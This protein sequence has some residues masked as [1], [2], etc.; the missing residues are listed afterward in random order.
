MPLLET[1]SVEALEMRQRISDLIGFG[2]Y[3][4]AEGEIKRFR[5]MV[6]TEYPRVRQELLFWKAL[7]EEHTGTD[8]RTCLKMMFQ[9][10]HCTVPY[11][12]GKDMGYWVFQREEIII[13]S[14]IAILYR[15]L[16]Q[17]DK[18]R[19]W[20]ETILHSLKEQKGRTGIWYV[21]Y[22][23][24]IGAY[25]NLLA[26]IG[27]LEDALY[28]DGEA[29]EDFMK[30]SHIRCV[31][32]LSYRVAWNSYEIALRD[33]QRQKIYQEKWREAYLT[34][35]SLAEFTYHSRLLTFLEN[36]VR[37]DKFLYPPHPIKA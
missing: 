6:D 8:L 7:L 21:G 23:I 15:K 32:S 35:Q 3:E 12:K 33:T 27:L 34:S 10:F 18:S 14:N 37:K 30:S 22:G 4:E 17:L 26:D 36:K 9:A 16:G 13:A 31:A 25:D 11:L 1:D 2:K 20:L 5:R 28:T 19:W 29:I 24:L